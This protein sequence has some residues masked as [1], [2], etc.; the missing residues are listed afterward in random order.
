[1]SGSTTSSGTPISALPLASSVAQTDTVLG[2]VGGGTT[3]GGDAHQVSVAVLGAAISSAAGIPGAVSSATQAATE[4]QA[5]AE[6]SY[7]ASTQAVQDQ[8]GVA[9]GVAQ[10]DKKAQLYLQGQSALAV[11]PAT[12][13]TADTPAQVSTLKPLLPLHS[14]T[15]VGA[16]ETSLGE[17]VDLAA[18][19]VQSS[20]GDASAA[21]VT[22]TATPAPRAIEK[23][24]AD[25]AHIDQYR[26]TGL[27][28][29][30]AL[31]SANSALKTAG[32]KILQLPPGQ[33]VQA[34][35]SSDAQA[36]GDI[37]IYGDGS[38]LDGATGFA[39]HDWY[40]RAAFSLYK[41][42]TPEQ[43]TNLHA[44]CAQSQADDGQTIVKIVTVGDSLLSEGDNA[45]VSDEVAGVTV[46]NI[47][48]AQ[49]QPI[50]PAAKFEFINRCLGGSAW[51]DWDSSTHGAPEYFGLASG[52]TLQDSTPTDAALILWHCGGNSG[53][54]F[55]GA[56]FVGAVA[57]QTARCP[58]ASQVFVIDGTSSVKTTTSPSTLSGV[59]WAYSWI[60][61]YCVT[62]GYG[63]IDVDSWQR[64]RRDG[65]YP[66]AVTLDQIGS[67]STWFNQPITLNSS[68][69]F[70]FPDI[71][72]GSG[73]SA[74]AC[75]DWHAMLVL[76]NTSSGL[77]I[78]LGSGATPC[79]AFLN[80]T[81]GSDG[82]S[83][84]LS[85]S[86][87]VS[88]NR[89]ITSQYDVPAAPI[90]GITLKDARLRIIAAL[91]AQSQNGFDPTALANPY[92]GGA[93]AETGLGF[94]EIFNVPVVRW[95]AQSQPQINGL[96]SGTK[97]LNLAVADASCKNPTVQPVRPD[98]TMYELYDSS[99]N[100]G[101]NN[102][103]HMTAFGWREMMLPPFLMQ[104]F[105]P[106]LPPNYTAPGRSITVGS[107]Q[108]S[109]DSPVTGSLVL[110]NQYTPSQGKLVQT[111]TSS[112]ANGWGQLIGLF[113]KADGTYP[114]TALGSG[115]FYSLSPAGASF[116]SVYTPGS[117]ACWGAQAPTAQPVIT[118]A[119]PTDPIV[120]QMLAVF[121]GCGLA[122]DGTT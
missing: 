92:S 117:F 80:W 16:S 88:P 77:E 38:T 14:G 119:K 51:S 43:L 15:A 103:A 76:P 11:T 47:I 54:G 111:Y 74:A 78:R 108:L 106:A 107:M 66:H 37:L 40:H 32:R 45:T 25:T 4:A 98:M 86:D 97:L 109:S 23:I 33:A 69:A 8:A 53:Y 67:K 93:G 31:T 102:D 34:D 13:G 101:G 68:G 87:G 95:R 121:A 82:K 73:V 70:L 9:G 83:F 94:F 60:Y 65:Y 1:M 72:N 44:V 55:A 89:S 10:L 105:R 5:A 114:A 35:G 90:I 48:I 99:L 50:Y 112:V 75:T 24:A 115:V 42:L 71:K 6:K 36:L 7:A 41:T 110:H 30:A 2:I 29:T 81:G 27:T 84:A 58:N 22:A 118:G 91:P 46:A 57:H 122:K 18:G 12:A 64:M 113:R 79:S 96:P 85:V 52:T 3:S 61:S 49:L 59:Q 100:A 120:Q 39:A 116:P 19:S 63:Y 26:A 62:Y 17:A 104:D 20:G 28:D 56:D 21:V